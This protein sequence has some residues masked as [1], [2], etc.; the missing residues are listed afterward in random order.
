MHAISSVASAVRIDEYAE[1]QL[2]VSKPFNL[3][4]IHMAHAKDERQARVHDEANW[5]LVRLITRAT[6]P[7]WEHTFMRKVR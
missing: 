1:L 3:A 4:Q 2:L 6:D 5:D 7:E